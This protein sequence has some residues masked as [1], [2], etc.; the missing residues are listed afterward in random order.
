MLI[1]TITPKRLILMWKEDPHC[2]WCGQMTHLGPF[3]VMP[4][5]AATT[6]HIRCRKSPGRQRSCEQALAEGVH[7]KEIVV[8]ACNRCNNL[9]GT[10]EERFFDRLLEVIR[11]DNHVRSKYA[12]QPLT[13]PL[14]IP[15]RPN[16]P[17]EA[18]PL[19]LMQEGFRL[20]PAKMRQM[21]DYTKSGGRYDPESLQ[22]FDP[23]QTA[24][25]AIVEFDDGV[26]YVRDG[27]HRVMSIFAGRPNQTIDPDEYVLEQKT[28]QGYLTPKLEMGYFTPFDPRTEVR[29]A[30]FSFFRWHIQ[31]LQAAGQ[32]PT[33][34]IM[35]NR[36]LYTRARKPEHDTVQ[37]FASQWFRKN[38]N[39]SCN[40]EASHAHRVI[41][42]TC[43]S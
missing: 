15:V 4:P 9:R 13:Q 28:Y 37:V 10:F 25:I 2:Y 22:L 20:P 39:F 32:D 29:I 23:E 31:A 40:S 30:D 42:E 19:R 24:L 8:L 12:D 1:E 11:E 17:V 27:F 5:N 35:A 3:E 6:D 26:R 14:K 33:S 18:G 7:H 36:H 21:I 38:E 41:E 34:F 16:V 43:S